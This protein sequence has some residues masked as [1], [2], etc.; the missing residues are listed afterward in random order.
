MKAT[1]QTTGEVMVYLSGYPFGSSEGKV[2]VP[3]SLGLSVGDLVK[4]DGKVRKVNF[5]GEVMTVK[6]D[7]DA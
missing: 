4:K 2:R 1:K 6:A 5:V 7:L 3:R